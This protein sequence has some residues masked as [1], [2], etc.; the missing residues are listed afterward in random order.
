MFEE[1][2]C[3]WCGKTPVVLMEKLYAQDLGYKVNRRLEVLCE[4][5]AKKFEEECGVGFNTLP[6]NQASLD[7]LK[8]V[9][10]GLTDFDLENNNLGKLKGLVDKA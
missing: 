8:Q 6:V 3:K 2:Y 9:F 7:K 4:A 10:A 5:C 1:I